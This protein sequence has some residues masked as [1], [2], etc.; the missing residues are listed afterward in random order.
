[1]SVNSTN[2]TANVI[3]IKEINLGSALLCQIPARTEP[4]FTKNLL[5]Q[6]K[7]QKKGEKY[8]SDK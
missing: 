3:E 1:M 8:S 2:T 7:S 6:E 5:K 4:N